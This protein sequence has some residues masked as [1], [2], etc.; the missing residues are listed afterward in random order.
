MA[1]ILDSAGVPMRHQSS[2]V[3][4]KD[5]SIGGALGSLQGFAQGYQQ[6]S[7]AQMFSLDFAFAAYL[8]SGLLQK[9]IDIP[10]ADRT[11][12]WRDWQATDDD[13][14]LIE[15]EE[16]RLAIRSKVKAAEVLR[17]LGGGALI[18][19][20]PGN[21]A[22]P[23]P[24]PSKGGL[25][26]VNVVSR[27][28]LQL[29]NIDDV[30][31]SP[32]YGEPEF[33]KVESKTGAVRIHPSR[34][35]AFRGEPYPVMSGTV[36][37]EDR[38]WGRARILRVMTEVARSDNG[39]RWFSELIKKAK[40][41]RF[42]ISNIADLDQ[43]TLSARVA[44]IAQGENT[45]NATLYSLP[46]KD[47]AGNTAGGE[48]IDDYQVNF[49]GIPAMQDSLDQRVSAVADIPFT[50]LMGRSPGG[51]NA[52]G[53]SDL[54][55]Y[56]DATH[57][58]QELE[59]RPCL[60]KLDAL[61][62][63]SAGV[64][65]DT[66][67]TWTFSPLSKANPKD[68]AE[69][70]DK[71][72]TALGKINDMAVMPAVAFAAGVQGVI[73]Q[74]GW[75]PGAIQKLGDMPDDVRFGIDPTAPLDPSAPDPSALQATGT[76]NGGKEAIQTSPTTRGAAPGAPARAANDAR[77]NDATP[78]SLYVQ[79]KLLNTAEFIAWAK[80][81]GFT[82]TTPADEIH[83]TITYSRAP[84]DWM[85]MGATWDGGDKGE[86]TVQPGGARIVEALGDK[87]AVVLLFASSSLSWRHEEMKQAGASFDFPEYQPHVTITYAKPEGLDLKTVEPFR[88]ALRFGPEIFEELDPN[89]QPGEA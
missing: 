87:G 36:S 74:N 67:N 3:R 9:T 81:Q 22:D 13:Q 63:P 30:L 89:F 19:A 88:G 21:P 34:V 57:A 18:L 35:I 8:G 58:S 69:R 51:M 54:A 62:L 50:R 80:G 32:T 5:A 79:R 16:K 33:F 28:Q 15:A 29:E 37:S 53:D 20:L 44:L 23:A 85:K 43:E 84:V 17:G 46:T 52:T 11:R 72:V 27:R 61:L 4:V 73:E 47:G 48:Q 83:C 41:L 25:Q 2:P 38:Y 65:L 12:A 77:F 70:F 40:L 31:T 56:H 55:N 64:A 45:L 10:A 7:F 1:G 26:A 60:E 24:V 39:A 49:T 6:S 82:T 71:T 86:I 42:G 75:M 78:R 66:D 14:Q 76:P 68:E 59:V